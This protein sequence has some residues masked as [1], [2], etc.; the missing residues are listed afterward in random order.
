MLT[1][2]SNIAALAPLVDEFLPKTVWVPDERAA[3]ELNAAAKHR[4]EILTGYAGL[5]ECAAAGEADVVVNAL[6]GKSGLAPTLA[7]VEAGKDI[8]LANK[9]TLVIAGELVMTRAR[10]KNVRI[11]PIDSEHSAIWQ[12]LPPSA[13]G[14][15]PTEAGYKYVKKIILTA[16]GGP[17]RTWER[18]RIAAATA[19]DAL[20]HPNWNMGPKITIDSATL[21]NKGLELIEAGWLFNQPL[22]R[23][24]IV[25][26]PQSIIHSMVEYADGSVIAQMGLPDMRL[27]ILYALTAPKR[28]ETSFPRL[29][30]IKCGSLTFESPDEEKF[31]CLG[32]AKE[33]AKKGGTLPA[34]MNYVNEYAVELFLEGVIGFYDISGLIADAFGSYTVKPA[35]SLDDIQ[36][37]EEWAENYCTGKVKHK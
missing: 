36:E 32:L 27:P 10:E 2:V 23:I 31:P 19:E 35:K 8:A 14:G 17:F 30:L 13:G 16:S 34:V 25:V 7:A 5:N 28:V 22:E 12:C 11:I 15:T 18:E 6:V 4:P 3:K 26:H 29:D 21:M 20:R 24:E 9:E 1:G 33:A 37:A